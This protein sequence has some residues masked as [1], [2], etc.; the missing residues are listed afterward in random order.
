MEQNLS[1]DEIN[2]MKGKYTNLTGKNGKKFVTKYFFVKLI[3]I[4]FCFFIELAESI[5]ESFIK[6][7]DEVIRPKEVGK[8]QF[9]FNFT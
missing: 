6:N 2:Q 3:I 1:E 4:I 9:I 7:R 5:Q 8:F